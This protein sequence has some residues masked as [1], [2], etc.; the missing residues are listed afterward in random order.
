MASIEEI[1]A[2]LRE[3][4]PGFENSIG[5]TKIRPSDP[6]EFHKILYNSVKF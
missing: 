3:A 5:T 2:R 4:K 6:I 1:E